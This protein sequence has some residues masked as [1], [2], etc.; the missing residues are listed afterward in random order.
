MLFDNSHEP[1][2]YATR[3]SRSYCADGVTSSSTRRY[4]P[5]RTYPNKGHRACRTAR[6]DNA[7]TATTKRRGPARQ[8]WSLVRPASSAWRLRSVSP[9]GAHV[10]ITGRNRERVLAAAR[11]I[12]SA[13][14][15]RQGSTIANSCA[16]VSSMRV[17]LNGKFVNQRLQPFGKADPAVVRDCQDRG[18]LPLGCEPGDVRPADRPV[19]V[20]PA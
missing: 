4:V 17:L 13:G 9:S 6:S 19:A 3:P 15:C 8:S 1:S 7:W 2:A 16:V 5:F 10:A 11:T 14:A 18:Q 12:R 20:A